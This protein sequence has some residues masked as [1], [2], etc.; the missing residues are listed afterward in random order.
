MDDAIHVDLTAKI[1]ATY[2]ANNKVDA[3]ELPRIVKDVHAS[4]AALGHRPADEPQIRTPAVSIRAS[5]K[6]DYLV[7]LECGTRQKMIKRHLLSAHGLTPEQYRRAYGLP[8]DYPI[9]AKN[10]SERRVQIAK[11]TGLGRK[12]SA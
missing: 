7:C 3:A 11:Q 4:L 2:A 10:Y 5:V 12:K 1:V 8:P 6:P 9:V